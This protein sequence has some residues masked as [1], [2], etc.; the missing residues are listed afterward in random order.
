MQRIF[1]LVYLVFAAG[2]CV[3]QVDFVEGPDAVQVRVGGRDFARYV[4]HDPNVFRPYFSNV[5]APNGVQVTRNNPPVAGVDSTDHAEFHP[6]IWVAFGDINGADFWRNQGRVEQVRFVDAP[7]LI[8][9][10][11][12]FAVENRYVDPQGTEQCREI[13]RY[14]F[15]QE[16][17]GVLLGISATFKAGEGAVTFGD[18]EEMGLGVRMATP[19]TVKQGGRIVNSD[20]AANEAGVW[21]KTSAW[22]AYTGR[23]DGKAV[24]VALLPHPDNFRASWF[25]AR[26]YGLLVANPFGRKAFT[27]GEASAVKIAPGET[28]TLRFGVWVF[29][30][31]PAALGEHYK[32]F[33]DTSKPIASAEKAAIAP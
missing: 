20:G 21:G 4:F 15:A 6:G 27:Q 14:T 11:A 2:W 29:E 19:L 33:V 9:G 22:C 3:A 32:T 18:Q 17:A 30:G 8:D 25:H 1:S 28:L 24:G 23:V 7:G 31:E 10:S 13:V 16:G 26:D 12:G 5:F